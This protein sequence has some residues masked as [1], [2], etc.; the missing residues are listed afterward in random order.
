MK[1]GQI[2][3]TANGFE[4][5]LHTLTVKASLQLFPTKSENEKAPGFRVTADGIEIGAAWEK[6]SKKDT[7]YLSVKLDDPA[8][9]APVYAVASIP[10]DG[11]TVDLRFERQRKKQED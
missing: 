6:T 10:A 7:P 4:G 1:I 2:T 8:F 3:K 5:T 9:A 11:E